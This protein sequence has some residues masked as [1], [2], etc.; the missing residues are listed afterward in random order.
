MPQ[1]GFGHLRFQFDLVD[2]CVKQVSY[3]VSQGSLHLRVY[4]YIYVHDKV[5]SMFII[6]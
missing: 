6:Y 3:G 5:I 4:V 1:I 2:N